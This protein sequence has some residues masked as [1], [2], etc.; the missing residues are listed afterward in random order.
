MLSWRRFRLSGVRRSFPSSFEPF[1]RV[2]IA[3]IDFLA[4]ADAKSECA[5][6]HALALEPRQKRFR[7][8]VSRPVM[9]AEIRALRPSA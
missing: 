6:I 1:G 3:H 7:Y 8:V 2:A 5:E 4:V 9:A